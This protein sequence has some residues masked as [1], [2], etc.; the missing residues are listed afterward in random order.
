LLRA[1]EEVGVVLEQVLRVALQDGP[2]SGLL[3]QR[4]WVEARVL[5]CIDQTVIGI[6]FK[7][8]RGGC[9]VWDE[10]VTRIELKLAHGVCPG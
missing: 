4:I 9:P 2:G 3:Q 10:V 5:A 6:E 8:A 7:H 1:V